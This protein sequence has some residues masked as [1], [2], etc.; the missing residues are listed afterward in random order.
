MIFAFLGVVYQNWHTNQSVWRIAYTFINLQH[1]TL[2]SCSRLSIT[3]THF[4]H[5]NLSESFFLISRVK[6][7]QIFSMMLI[8]YVPL[9]KT[10]MRDR[11]NQV[12]PAYEQTS[13]TIIF[14]I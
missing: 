7:I 10:R 13:T 12:R 3:Q 5:L 2:P 8:F 9:R 4:K 1:P 14:S 6:V 11:C